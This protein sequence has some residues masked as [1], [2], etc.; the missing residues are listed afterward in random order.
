MPKT[1]AVDSLDPS[2]LDT[3]KQMQLLGGDVDVDDFHLQMRRGAGIQ[4][5]SS[6][7][8]AIIDRTIDGASSLTVTVDDEVNRTI[9]L[10]GMLGHGVD[11][12][13]DGLYFTL[14]GVKKTGRAVTLTFE[15]REVNLLRKY[16]SFI[17]AQRW[18]K[19]NPQGITRAQFALRMIREVKEVDLKWT[20][21]ELHI[22]QAVSDLTANQYLIGPDLQPTPGSNQV[23][24][25]TTAM[26]ERSKGI[27]LDNSQLKVRGASAQRWQIKNANIILQ[28]GDAANASRK[29][30]IA[31]MMT[32][33]DESS[34]YNYPK[35]YPSGTGIFQQNPAYW[36]ATANIATDAAAFF[37]R[38]K[39]MN[40]DFPNVSLATL[41]Y[42]VQ[43]NKAG[44]SAYAPFEQEGTA[45]V[46]A[47]DH[48]VGD[49]QATQ[50]AQ[51]AQIDQGTNLFIRG[52]ISKAKGMSGQYIMTPE[53]SW[54]CLQRIAQ[55][56]NWRCFIVSGRVYFIS[57]HWLFKSKP[58]MTI[59]EDSDGIDWI[60]YDYDEGKH[61]ATCTITAH[62][63]RWSAPPGSTIDITDMGIIDGKY[64]VE[65]IS[66]SL[67]DTI[68]TIT[69]SKPLPILPEPVSLGGVPSG[70]AGGAGTSVPR[71]SLTNA[72]QVQKTVVAFAKSQLGVPYQWGADSPGVAFDCSGLTQAAYAAA[73]IY[74]PHYSGHGGQWD[75][76]QRIKDRSDLIPADLVFFEGATD[77]QH[78][79]IY[80][81]G[82]KMIDAPHTG[83]NVRTEPVW[84]SFVGGTRPWVSR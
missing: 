59:S 37:K 51:G 23:Q 43:H 69:A 76:G 72:N 56:V 68:A 65:E 2:H 40:A 48:V 70:L 55:E 3:A 21:P 81:G 32:A 58:F 33:I 9:Q 50:Y 19:Q 82:G 26:Q 42:L 16:K 54:N 83:A 67:Y 11:V 14:V 1:S 84:D 36:P 24:D 28:T 61:K 4:I 63:K 75:R 17:M 77:P 29:V 8:S 60:D 78:V 18:S 74:L 57:E 49:S 47:Y 15:E 80:I 27:A 30:M 52:Q 38:C 53:N 45:F 35:G 79:G 31:S 71:D 7:T 22:H 64:L 39:Q 34:F 5:E 10:S 62:L 6:I 25:A 20:I 12:N 73:G 13:L 41:C 66:R 46:N 44:A